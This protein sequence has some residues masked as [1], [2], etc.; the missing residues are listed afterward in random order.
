MASPKP[1]PLMRMMINGL[2]LAPPHWVLPA[3]GFS[4]MVGCV[5]FRALRD[6]GVELFAAE[7]AIAERVRLL[8]DEIPA[9]EISHVGYVTA[10]L[11]AAGR[12][13]ML[14]L[15]RHLGAHLAAQMPELVALFGTTGLA[16]HFER[17]PLDSV[18]DDLAGKAFGVRQLA[19]ALGW[20]EHRV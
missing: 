14:W 2:V 7:P 12:R 19:A 11:G 10:Q 3:V 6:R 1:V 9:D 4:E 20:E 8:Y 17:F 15:Y 13:I 5:L 18:A 16:R